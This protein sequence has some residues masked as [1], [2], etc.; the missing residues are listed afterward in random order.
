MV[1]STANTSRVHTLLP[2]GGQRL[3]LH[4]ARVGDGVRIQRAIVDE[5]VRIAAGVEIAF[6]S[7]SD[8]Q[9]GFVASSGIVVIPANTY[10]GSSPQ[11]LSSPGM[12]G[13]EFFGEDPFKTEQHR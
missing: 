1:G 2:A 10:V 13:I 6:D 5:N 9:Y 8:R 4:N 3:L 11:S 7:I 12:N